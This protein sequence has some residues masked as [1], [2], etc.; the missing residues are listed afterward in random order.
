MRI[1][2]I[3]GDARMRYAAQLLSEKHETAWLGEEAACEKPFGAVMLPLPLTRDGKTVFAPTE[4]DPITFERAFDA[5]ARLA[6]EQ[7]LVLAGGENAALSAFCG[8]KGLS[9]ANYFADETLTLQNAALTAEAALCLLSQSGGNAL[10]GSNAV[11]AGS[12]RI[13]FFLAE[14]L[15]ACGAS[16]TLAARNKDKRALAALNGYK[17]VPL[18]ELPDILPQTDFTANTIPAPLFDE[19]LFSRMREN[20]V[21]Q[22]LATLPQ[23]PQ[24]AL[25]ERYGIK[26]IFAGGLPGKYYP[27]TAGELIAQ[28]A[29]EM[30]REFNCG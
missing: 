13:A 10:L 26:Y 24:K 7:T 2:F 19:T 11:I 1:L 22:E 6:D 8:E 20:S 15:R 16:V 9:C 23:Q 29:E 27:K 3:G 18:E 17:T 30:L 21:Y 5:I 4:Q 12:G 25:A 14:R 28:T